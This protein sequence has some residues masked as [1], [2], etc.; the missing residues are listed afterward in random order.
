[1]ANT[2]RPRILAVAGTSAGLAYESGRTPSASSLGALDAV[3]FFLAAAQSGFG[4]YVA[5]FLVARNWTPQNI[6]FVLTAAAVAGLLSQMPAGAVLDTIRSKGLAMMLAAVIIAGAALVIALWPSFP[7]VLTALMIQAIAGGFLGLSIACVTLGLVGHAALGERLGRNQRFASMGGV[8]AAAFMGLVSYFLSYR[9]IFLLAAA[10]V[11]PL[12]IALG[13]IKPSDIDFGAACG[14]P[15]HH[16]PDRPARARLL[17]LWKNRAL[18]IFAGAVFLFQMANASMLPLAAGALA[19]SEG[20]G[21][22]LLIS[23]LIIVPQVIVA[24]MAPWVG[25][26]AKAWGRRPLLLAGFAALPVRAL[27]FAWT[28]EPPILIGAQILD[29]ISGTVLGVLTALIIADVT[30]GSGRFNLAQGA[31]GTVSGL[32]ASVST[33]LFGQIVGAFGQTAAFMSIAA[34]ALTALFLLWQLMPETSSLPN[35]QRDRT[36]IEK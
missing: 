2:P 21:S 24:L 6:G 35:G 28:S 8:F 18:V 17:S 16:G 22:S 25:R 4:P 12:V 3:N 7:L 1:M 9:A 29:G 30:A 19:Y 5:S 32:G 23:A 27:V 34:V 11:L 36:T 31:V 10:L 26:Q 20:A 15:R 13:C 14:I 33:A